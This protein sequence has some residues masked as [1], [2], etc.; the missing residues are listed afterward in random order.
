[1]NTTCVDS[2]EAGRGDDNRVLVLITKPSGQV[3]EFARRASLQQAQHDVAGLR[4]WG[5]DAR[6][7]LL[8]PP[9]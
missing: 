8:E 2:D 1:M 5:I 7:E 9:R 4:F 3:V 6:V